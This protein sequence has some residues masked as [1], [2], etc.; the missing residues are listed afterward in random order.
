MIRRTWKYRLYPTGAQETELERQ[1]GVACDLYNAALEQRHHDR[2]RPCHGGRCSCVAT[3]S[4]MTVASSA[5]EPWAIVNKQL[6]QHD[7]QTFA[8]PADMASAIFDDSSKIQT[9]MQVIV[10]LVLL[11]AMGVTVSGVW[12]V[13]RGE[14]GGLEMVGGGVFGL[15]GLMAAMTVVM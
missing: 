12:Q 10:A 5:A 15:V 2:P 9:A 8:N 11:G 6:A 13:I 7:R 14:R 4:A 1:L 3:L